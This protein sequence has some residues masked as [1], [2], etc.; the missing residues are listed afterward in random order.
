[1]RHLILISI[2]ALALVAPV[3]EAQSAPPLLPNDHAVRL[4]S[5]EGYEF[6]DAREI[7]LIV[8][9]AL[10]GVERVVCGTNTDWTCIQA[11]AWVGHRALMVV[12]VTAEGERFDHFKG[13]PSDRPR[14]CAAA[15]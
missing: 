1:M 7:V 15:E 5:V 11:T 8:S 4:V 12:R 2:V 3:A 13:A 9:S 14:V 10:N 6:S